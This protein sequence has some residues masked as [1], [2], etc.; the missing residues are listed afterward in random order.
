VTCKELFG[1]D[2]NSCQWNTLS[3]LNGTHVH[4][5]Y[6]CT[7]TNQCFEMA[8]CSSCGAIVYINDPPERISSLQKVYALYRC[9]GRDIT[10]ISF[11]IVHPG[12]TGNNRCVATVRSKLGAL[13]I[14]NIC[15]PSKAILF[16]LP[17]V[18]PDHTQGS[19]TCS[20]STVISFVDEDVHELCQGY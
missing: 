11:S 7:I 8:T 15:N 10:R 1:D 16:T 6:S 17:F 5:P 12:L 20:N 18:T 4:R 19:A 9:D 2:E 14:H 3:L 13:R